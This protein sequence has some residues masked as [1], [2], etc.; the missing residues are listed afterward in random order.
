LRRTIAILAALVLL[1]TIPAAVNAGKATKEKDHFVGISCDGIAPTSGT[2]F[3]FLGVSISDI[4]GPD[5]SVE[6]W[7]AASPVGPPD[8][9]RDFDSPVDASYV[10]GTFSATIPLLDSNGDPAGTGTVQAT[11]TPV[12]EP[13]PIDDNFRFGNVTERFTGL[14]QP[15]AAEGTAMIGGKTFDLGE[16]FAEDTHVTTF[17][18]NPN[19]FVERFATADTNCVVENADGTI[20]GLFID[21]SSPDEV[22][23]DAN[24]F[25]GPGSP[26]AANGLVLLTDGSGSGALDLY[27]PETGEP[28]SGTASIDLALTAGDSYSYVLN[29]GSGKQV[30]SG[31]L[32]DVEGTLTFPGLP[33]FD[34]TDCVAFAGEAK[35]SFH[36]PQG[37]K[38]KGK[39]PANDLPAG[40]LRLNVG[41][42]ASQA[43]RAAALD[44]EADYPCMVF[45]DPFS[46]ETEV[47]PVEHT[48]WF[49]IAGTGSEITVDTAGS[50]FDTVAGAY[51]SDGL[52]GFTNIACVDDV[53]LDPIGRTLQSAVRFPTT[54]GI[55]YWVQVGGFPGFQSYGNLRVA[56]R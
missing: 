46:G 54:T 23:V 28:V 20:A 29:D 4:F 2:G 41:G 39:A 14:V 35:N 25:E 5:A 49:R 19:S 50:D 47:I 45:D 40:A 55:T 13:F 27:N 3:L 51:V 10:G 8:I 1:A 18:T 31:Q 43:T 16:C 38:P 7:N 44:Q 36:N 11:L 52:G 21:A 34:L 30:V 24:L 9:F 17:R 22:F 12:G 42:K 6:M 53:P 56:V 26:L 48:V 15:L 32:I 33:S 37:P